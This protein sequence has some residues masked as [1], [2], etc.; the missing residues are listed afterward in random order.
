MFSSEFSQI[1]KN[2]Y[3]ADHVQKQLYFTRLKNCH[4]YGSSVKTAVIKTIVLEN[5]EIYSEMRI[6]WLAKPQKEKLNKFWRWESFQ[7][8]IK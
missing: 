6:Q 3:F 4:F 8:Q 2:I 7:F 5:I 1:L